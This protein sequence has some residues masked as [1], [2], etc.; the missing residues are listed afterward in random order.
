MDGVLPTPYGSRYRECVGTLLCHIRRLGKLEAELRAS[1][2]IRMTAPR[3]SGTGCVDLAVQK[4]A[5]LDY[6][7][8]M[9]QAARIHD[10]LKFI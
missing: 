9:A 10:I 2:L 8:E 6:R 1:E 3:L 5:D 7:A 4:L